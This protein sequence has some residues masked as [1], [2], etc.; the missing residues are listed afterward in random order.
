MRR[1]LV[2]IAAFFGCLYA[3]YSQTDTEFWFAPP[4][5]TSAHDH[6]PIYLCLTSFSESTDVVISQPANPLFTPITVHLNSNDFQ[7]VNLT[8]YESMLETAPINTVVSHGLKVE[9]GKKISAYY[10]FCNN[11]SEIY[12]LKG[13]NA[14]GTHFIVPSQSTLDCYLSFSPPARNCI[15]IVA[16]QD[17]TVVTII[18]SN[19]L[20]GTNADTIVVTLDAGECYSIRSASSYA[21]GHLGN[22]V[23]VSS[24]PVA[25]NSTDDSVRYGES[26]DLMGDQI[27]PVN[28][29]GNM[30]VAVWTHQTYETVSIFPTEDNTHVFIDGASLPAA[31]LNL[32][33]EYV[34]H[35]TDNFSS[36][37]TLVTS[38]KPVVV[39]QLSGVGNEVGGTQLPSLFCTGS[40]D[41]VYGRSSN[42]SSMYAYI[43]TRTENVGGFSLQCSTSG[44]TLL[45]SD[46]TPVPYVPEWSYCYKNFS[47]YVSNNTSMRVTNSLGKFHLGVLDYSSGS[48]TLGYFSAYNHVGRAWFTAGGTYCEHTDVELTYFTEDVDSVLFV[49]PSGDTLVQDSLLLHDISVA[50]TGWYRILARSVSDCD[51]VFWLTDSLRVVVIPTVIWHDTLQLPYNQLPYY[52]APADTL[53]PAD[54]PDSLTFTYSLATVDGCDTVVVQTVIVS[55]RVPMTLSM[56][57]AT[58]TNCGSGCEYS[59]PS[60]MINEV[61]LKP[62]FGDGS[63]VGYSNGSVMEGEWIELY[64]PHKCDSVDISGYFL[65][66]NAKDFSTTFPSTFSDRTGGFVLPPGT[67]VPP[68]GFCLVRGVNAPP[69]PDSL[70]VANGGNAVEV[71]VDS[72]YCVGDG[73]RLWFPNAGGWFAFYNAQGEPQDAIYWEDSTN[74]CATCPP[75]VPSVPD[76]SFADTLAA[77]SAIPAAKK[78]YIGENTETGLSLRRVP[79]GGAW[80]STP[81][82][83]TYASCN[84]TC[85]PPAAPSYNGYAVASVTG[86]QP[87]Y[88]YL[89]DDP[90]AQTTDTASHLCGGVYTVTVTD[91]LG[92]T[93]SASV[94]INDFVP[95]VT[96]S[97]AHFCFSDSVGV[98]H[99]FPSGGTY[100]GAPMNGDT[101][102]FQPGTTEYY[103]TYTYSDSNYCSSSAQFQ[104]TV[105][106]N[107]RFESRTLCSAE[108]PYLWYNQTVTAAGTYEAVVPAGGFCDSI[109]TLELSVIQQP[110]LTI[111]EDVI[112]DDGESATL[113]VSGATS[114]LWTPA[115]GLSSATDP[116]PVVTPAQSTLYTVTGFASEDCV[117]SASLTVILRRHADTTLCESQLPLSWHGVTFDDSMSVELTVPGTDGPESLLALHLHLSPNTYSTLSDTVFENDLPVT[118]NGITFTDGVSDT[119]IVIP[120]SFGCDSVITYTLTVCRNANVVV[121]S[122]VCEGNLPFWW[123]GQ[124]LDAAGT[125][126]ALLQTFCGGDSLVTLHLAVIDTALSIVSLTENF[127]EDMSAELSAITTLTDYVW[128]TG[129][130]SPTITVVYPGFYTVTA[131]TGDCRSV[132]HYLLENC[133]IQLYLPNAITPSK[134]EGL[135]D[136]FCIPAV[137][138]RFINDFEIS[139]FNRWGEMVFYSTDKNFKWGGEYRGGV[140][141]NSTYNWI[142]R[143][144]DAN[145]KAY[146]KKGS[147]TVL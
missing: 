77:F 141:Y 6:T 84:D 15:E 64:N 110:Q 14:L 143:Y 79:D 131:S 20:D 65:G 22:T 102:V 101:I 147:V 32:G 36:R 78:H 113:H 128:S 19:A 82:A 92:N 81:V 142:V 67:V 109:I 54:T 17:N 10:Q 9:S 94:S 108:L 24:K 57:S 91:A 95:T 50:D 68:Q 42:S 16:T 137:T 30:Y 48:T 85:V 56:E 117:S 145:G 41:V 60:I 38:D 106:P 40:E 61:M 71:V 75:C 103:L 34:Y 72:R 89:W 49:T 98:L 146:L 43:L 122:A 58:N 12:T 28:Y 35:H 73:Y 115:V 18:P 39:W 59:G 105:T 133:Q 5:I 135:N 76:I 45:A 25:V 51:T 47:S 7:S 70:L 4:D 90:L 13:R 74:F 69:V 8:A 139:I 99:G 53:I 125:T 120:N 114:Y 136:W 80:S 83:A 37:V 121:D 140:L 11:N 23:I 31:T 134:S 104:V 124:E 107:T 27:L 29:A 88:S 46:F 130:Q 100:T 126:Q 123:N 66:N 62:E 93:L 97:D 111:S 2:L 96:H 33:E 144:T 138:Q 26:W 1:I 86:G 119:I 87:P 44:A 112:V 116:D 129:E 127:C 63:I 55:G 118:F 132:S 21:S 52:F 3:G